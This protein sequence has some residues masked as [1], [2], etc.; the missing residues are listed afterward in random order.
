[1][2][3]RELLVAPAVFFWLLSSGCVEK[4]EY[5]G[6]QE[7]LD[8]AK[9]QLAETKDPLKKS[10]DQLTDLQ[11]HRYQTFASGGRTWRLDSAKGSTCVLLASDQDWKSVK[12]KEESCICEDFYRDNELPTIEG[13]TPE[14]VGR[15]EERVK[16][17]ADRA[18]VLGCE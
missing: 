15:Y 3:H 11:A 6:L 18:K 13:S 8:D 2:H 16:R 9:K 7:K 17:F 12:T 14:Q 1:M 4:T 5:D 10:Q